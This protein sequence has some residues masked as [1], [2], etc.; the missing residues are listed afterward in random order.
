MFC[1]FKC[2]CYIGFF[3]QLSVFIIVMLVFT[4]SCC[5][6]LLVLVCYYFIVVVCIDVCIFVCLFALAGFF[7]RLCFAIF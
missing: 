2:I 3:F 1:V 4:F 7:Y 5:L 6:H